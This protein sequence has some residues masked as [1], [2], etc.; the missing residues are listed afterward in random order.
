MFI[1]MM[2]DNFLS[3]RS[4]Q[5]HRQP[6]NYKIYIKIS[7]ICIVWYLLI[8]FDGNKSH[9]YTPNS[10]Q[11]PCIFQANQSI[12]IYRSLTTKTLHYPSPFYHLSIKWKKKNH[13]H[14][15]ESIHESILPSGKQCTWMKVN[16]FPASP[17]N[18]YSLYKLMLLLN[19]R[20]VSHIPTDT[21]ST[22]IR[23]FTS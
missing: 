16:D 21:C 8:F 14:F 15:I 1:I 6:C 20:S 2:S 12:S 23:Y 22:C 10:S 7:L 13:Q 5:Q 19:V 9:F 4:Y 3:P 11:I 17:S 18:Q